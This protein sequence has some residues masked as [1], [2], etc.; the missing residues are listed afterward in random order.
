MRED[1]IR[2]V[3]TE[4]ERIDGVERYFGSKCLRLDVWG[5]K[6]GW[7]QNDSYTSVLHTW[8]KGGFFPDIGNMAWGQGLEGTVMSVVLGR[9]FPEKT[10]QEVIRIITSALSR[11]GFYH[12]FTSWW[13]VSCLEVGGNGEKAKLKARFGILIPVSGSC[14]TDR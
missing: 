12:I 8:M 5:E 1:W 2:M 13:R 11:G 9:G 7:V 6:M 3:K 10:V 4:M 14:T